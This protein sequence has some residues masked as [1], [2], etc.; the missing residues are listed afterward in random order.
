MS[1]PPEAATALRAQHSVVNDVARLATT[2]RIALGEGKGQIAFTTGLD[3]MNR[4]RTL[5]CGAHR[6]VR[7]ARLDDIVPRRRPMMIKLDVEGFE[8]HVLAGADRTLAAPLLLA[9][10]SER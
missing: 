10:Q 2:Q 8:E 5:G 7:H 6:I 4:I 9:V 3:T 1:R